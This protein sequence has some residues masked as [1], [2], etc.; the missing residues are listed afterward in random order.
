VRKQH[1]EHNPPTHVQ[2]RHPKASRHTDQLPMGSKLP[3]AVCATNNTA[4]EHTVL[5][6]K[7]MVRGGT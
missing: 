1:R 2:C 6:D 7:H 5:T 3:M 4:Y